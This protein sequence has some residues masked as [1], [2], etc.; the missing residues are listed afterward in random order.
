IPPACNNLGFLDQEL[1]LTWV[2]D[3]IA[4]FGGDKSKV[5]IMVRAISLDT[6]Q[7]INVTF[8]LAGPVITRRNSSESPPFRAGIMLSSSQVFTHPETRLFKI[9]RVRECSRRLQAAIMLA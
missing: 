5:T 3:N 4:Q 1:A 8:A 9:Q 6:F 7:R 2:Q